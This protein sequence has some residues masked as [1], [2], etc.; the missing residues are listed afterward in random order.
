[1]IILFAISGSI[2][3]HLNFQGVGCLTALAQL[4]RSVM[5]TDL[6]DELE[7]SCAVITNLYVYSTYA[8]FA[9]TMLVIAGFMKKRRR[10]SS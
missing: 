3:I 7:T 6:L 8:V 9:G 2:A 1:M 4:D 5:S 10:N